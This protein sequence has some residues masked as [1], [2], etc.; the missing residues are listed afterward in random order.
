[1]PIIKDGT[2]LKAINFNGTPIKKVIYN[3]TVVFTSNITVDWN[4]YI[5]SSDTGIYIEF[6]ATLADT[7]PLSPSDVVTFRMDDIQD[8]DGNNLEVNLTIAQPTAT[9]HTTVS[10]ISTTLQFLVNG[11]LKATSTWSPPSQEG[12]R[13]GSVTF[14]P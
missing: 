14:E 9:V 4:I 7:E 10:I 11:V 3:G 6:G 8:R 12:R 1:M 2:T 13:T 5:F